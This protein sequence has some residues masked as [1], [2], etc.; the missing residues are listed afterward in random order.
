MNFDIDKVK[1]MRL[2]E[3]TALV[4]FECGDTDLNDFLLNDAKNYLKSMLAVTYLLKIND[5]TVAYFCLSYDGLTR[6]AILREEE[7]ALWNK[8]GRK[9]PNSKRRR[10]YP[11]VKIGRLAVSK[12]YS[13][14][15]IGRLII[16]AVVMMYLTEQHHAGCRFITVDAYR[17]ALSFYEKNNFRFLTTKDLEDDIRTMYF[18]LKSV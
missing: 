12:K 6:S 8:V 1:I 16:K 17:S 18:D 4:S 13:G 15:G 2:E 7:K 10:T 5:E 9:I 3:D 11:A 14:L